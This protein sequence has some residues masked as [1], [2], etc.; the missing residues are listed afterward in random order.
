MPLIGLKYA[1]GIDDMRYLRIHI[2]YMKLRAS[3][4]CPAL[5]NVQNA[6]T[7]QMAFAMLLTTFVAPQSPSIAKSLSIQHFFPPKRPD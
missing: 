2:Q 7:I 5:S 6:C 4:S 1:I 3:L